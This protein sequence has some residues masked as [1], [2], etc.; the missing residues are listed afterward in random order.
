M[1]AV[2]EMRGVSKV[3]GAGA[4]AVH[5]LREVDLTVVRGELVA[6]MG[7]SGSGKSSMLTIAGSLE[8]PSE[9]E[10][11]VGGEALNGMSARQRSQ[12][13]PS[14]VE[15]RDGCSALERPRDARRADGSRTADEK[16]RL[17]SHAPILAG[18]PR[19]RRAPAALLPRARSRA[20]VRRAVPLLPSGPVARVNKRTAR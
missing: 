17:R 2:L 16:N 3:Y 6:V 20:A 8:E 19:A 9:G 10:V 5:A 15:H 13:R 4:N 12:L 11:L 14:P 1:N 7:P 18:M